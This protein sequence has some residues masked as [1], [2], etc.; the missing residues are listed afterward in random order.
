MPNILI[1]DDRDDILKAYK[2]GLE[3]AG[4][5]WNVLTAKNENEAEIILREQPIDVVITDLVMITEESG[6]NV[7]HL[8]KDKD[9]LLPVI[10]VTAFDKKLDRY[11]AFELGAFDCIAKGTPGIK[12]I[13]EIIVKT[14]TAIQLRELTLSEIENQNKLTLVLLIYDRC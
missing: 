5:D 10:I 7:L 9:P 3:D 11:Q 12:T 2:L 13:E 6:M 4:L 14:K 1:V 8:A